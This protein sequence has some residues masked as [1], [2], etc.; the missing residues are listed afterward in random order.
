MSKQRTND[1]NNRKQVQ[2]YFDGLCQPVNPGGTAC[3][4]FIIKNEEGNTIHSDY[5]VAAHDSTNNV[6][7]Y[8][9]LIKSLEWLIKNNYHNQTIVIMGDSML[10]IHQLK[11]EFQVKAP[12]IIPLYRKAMSLVSKFYH[13]EFEW[14]P[15]E[16]NKEADKLTCMAYEEIMHPPTI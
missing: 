4:A 15:R 5:G 16:Q 8:T 7:E 10:V 13:I 9:G 12:T 14:I 11:K 3:F 1:N 6:A 2:V